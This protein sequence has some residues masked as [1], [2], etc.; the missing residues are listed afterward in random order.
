MK[1]FEYSKL[2]EE[3][4]FQSQFYIKCECPVEYKFQD[5]HY[6]RIFAVGLEKNVTYYQ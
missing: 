1:A 6:N 3:F 2:K 4:D 5:I